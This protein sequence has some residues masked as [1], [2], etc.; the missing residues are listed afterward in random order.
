MLAGSNTAHAQSIDYKSLEAL[1]GEPVTTSATGT[2]QRVSEVPANM[3]IITADEIRQSGSRDIP[4]ILSRVPGL[5]ILQTGINTYDVG[6]RGYQQ[7]MQPRLLVLV[8]G[9]QVFLDDYSRTA[10]HNIPVN[11]DNIR[12]IEVIKGASSALFGSNAAGG[13]INIITY[14]PIHDSNEV[15]AAS[16]GTQ[17]TSTGDLTVMRQGEWGGTRTTIGGYNASE[18]ETFRYPLDQP[19]A[20]PAH[21]YVVNN[22][23]F[24]LTPKT[25]I[26]T[27]GTFSRSTGNTADPT[28]GG[29]MGA[30]RIETYSVRAGVNAD[31]KF[32]LL[33]YDN[34]FNHSDITLSEPTDG[35]A[36]YS[37]LTSLF[38]TNIKDQFKIGANNIFRV[39]AEYKY[40]SFSM[41]GAQLYEAQSPALEEHN[42]AASATWVHKFNDNVAWTNAVRA[43][44]LRMDETG[45]LMAS[46]F[47]P[48]SDYDHSLHAWS[49][50]STVV[51]QPT[52]RDSFRLGYGR[53]VQL[54]SLINSGYGLFQF[55]GAVDDASTE[56]MWQGN[57]FLKPTTVDD[58]SLDY[59][60][61]VPGIF[62]SVTAGPYYEINRN[63]VTPLLAVGTVN[64]PGSLC[65]AAC[66]YGESVNSGSSY[67]YGGEIEI[68]G[69][70]PAGFRWDA[71]YSYAHVHD[72]AD[73]LAADGYQ[74]SAP[75][76][77][78]RLLLGFSR[79]EWELDGSGQYLTSTNMLRSQTGGVTES[80]IAV[81]GYTTFAARIGYKLSDYFTFSLSGTNINRSVI[82][83]SPYPAVER[84][85]FATLTGT[86]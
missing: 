60:R 44:Y 20:K 19:S 42:L 46:A 17:G 53:G 72:A 86:F 68:K 73:V 76:H 21:V 13:V 35:G 23:I 45:T 63:I 8:D 48:A 84:Q 5:D 70:N 1:F 22:S 7:P 4:Q 66:T 2:P 39:G 34:Y 24:Q 47:H 55:F 11:V 38:N 64:V 56:S 37:F 52:A 62:S 10:W 67:G 79:D 14:S 65:G 16:F 69:H 71:S 36:P 3:T 43:D 75:Q 77:H 40:K 59:T 29:V 9:R 31:T 18:F 74:G 27:E 41:S 61:K 30:E 49:G 26:F 32:G 83:E 15:Y 25:Q 85:V 28:D 12:Q 58:F 50:N 82:E 6:V 54:P 33:T 51:W 81:G 57:P 80:A 78:F